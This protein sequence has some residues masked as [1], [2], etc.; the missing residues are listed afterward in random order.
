MPRF[1]IHK[2]DATNLHWDFR[3]ELDGVLKSWAIPKQPPKKAGTKRLAVHVDDHDISYIDFEGK[4]PEGHYGAGKVDIWDSGTFEVLS[5]NEEKIEF[6]LK[7]KKLKGIYYLIRFKKAG[8]KNWL[9]FR[10]KAS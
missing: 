10:K 5:R 1:V 8:S 4:I 3:L 6:E 7:G 9:F 2:H